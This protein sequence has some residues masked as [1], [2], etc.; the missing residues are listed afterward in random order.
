MIW[1][2]VSC[3][4][5][6]ISNETLTLK[7]V[8]DA[9][10]E[11]QT[12][13]GEGSQDVRA[14]FLEKLLRQ[15]SPAGAGF[16]V[17]IILGKLRTGFSDM[18]IIDAF[19]WML[20]GNK[21]LSKEIEHAYN[22]CAD[23]GLIAYTL[24]KDGQAGLEHIHITVGIPILPSLAERLATALEIVDKLG[25]C[26]AQPKLDGFRLQVHIVHSDKTKGPKVY[27]YSRNLINMTHMFPDLT[28]RS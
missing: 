4:K 26:A 10:V 24:K 28:Q 13:S 14:Q 5:L 11:L 7:Y 8:F 15:L 27:F 17:R 19:S 1:D 25:H 22:V 18:T 20:A 12:I 6:A 23:L 2:V 16:V 21:S 9:L 3:T